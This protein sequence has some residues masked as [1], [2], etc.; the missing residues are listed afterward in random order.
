MFASKRASGQGNRHHL[1]RL[2]AAV[3]AQKMQGYTGMNTSTG[4][5]R[6]SDQ[7]FN[8]PSA[9]QCILQTSS[10]SSSSSSSS[11]EGQ[12]DEDNN[13]YN[14]DN[15]VQA[16]IVHGQSRVTAED[17]TDYEFNIIRSCT[18][19]LDKKRGHLPHMD[20]DAPVMRGSYVSTGDFSRALFGCFDRNKLTESASNDI[21]QT[22]K[23]QLPDV[24][25]PVQFS[26]SGNVKSRRSEHPH[27]EST[28]LFPIFVPKWGI[29]IS[30]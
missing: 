21:L 27:E 3:K 1:N 6:S 11:N 26:N 28:Q 23:T 8:L 5:K 17:Y 29:L 15:N 7:A 2:K 13:N 10:S 18:M 25:I 12:M 30:R 9:A 22:L 20:D 19:L 24:N 16:D 4:M 14:H